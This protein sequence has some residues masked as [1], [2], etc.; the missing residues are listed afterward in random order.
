MVSSDH[1]VNGVSTEQGT[2]RTSIVVILVFFN[3]RVNWFRG[4]VNSKGCTRSGVNS[5]IHTKGGI[6]SEVR[7]R[8]GVNFDHTV[9]GVFTE[10]GTFRTSIVRFL[11]GKMDKG[12]QSNI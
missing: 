4:G 5:K 7:T 8:G 2:F 11:F 6:N 10:Q 12:V 1:T 3:F 9:N